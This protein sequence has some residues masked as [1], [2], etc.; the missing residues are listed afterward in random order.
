MATPGIRRGARAPRPAV[1]ATFLDDRV[2]IIDLGEEMRV[3][4]T[5]VVGGRGIA[6]RVLMGRVLE[7]VDD[8]ER[9]AESLA[10]DA[11]LP[12]GTPTFLTSADLR[13]SYVRSRGEADGVVAEVHATFGLSGMAC[14][15]GSGGFPAPE[16]GTVN[17][18][19]V[20]GQRL[21]AQGLLD[22][23]R[24]ASEAKGALSVL[25]GFSC[26]DSAAVG[27]VSDATLIAAPRGGDAYSGPATPSGRAIL[28]AMSSAFA[29]LAS[30]LG[31]RR[32]LELALGVSGLRYPG[33][34]AE[35]A[36]RALRCVELARSAS[37]LGGDPEEVASLL[38]DLEGS[39]VRSFTDLALRILRTRHGISD[40]GPPHHTS[41]RSSAMDSG[42]RRA[43]HS[44]P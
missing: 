14:L 15:D 41:A 24:T 11:G 2:I 22:A 44:G 4:G 6:R 10:R 35:A 33:A 31:G 7:Y 12:P 19:V 38:S 9:Y 40:R 34:S 37:L 25:S 17:I 27:T 36:A 16:T 18:L 20:V 32:R 26:R 39:G 8:F 13:A 29:E 3:L 21:S 5:T 23:F 28:R 1:S 42:N 30:R 43:A